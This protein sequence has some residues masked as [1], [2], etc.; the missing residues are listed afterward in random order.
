MLK[1]FF[2]LAF[3]NLSKNKS[4]AFVNI[5]GL[6]VGVA[7]C[8]LSFLNY[9][10]SR[11]F[12]K[13]HTN[14]ERIYR[15]DSKLLI[16]NEIQDWGTVPFALV[17][18]A[19]ENIPG[20]ELA[21]RF[22][23]ASGL[24][25]NGDRVFNERIR[26]VGKD[27]FQIFTF[28]VE[29]G[30]NN[31]FDQKGRVILSDRYA[32]KYFGDE[33]PIGRTLTIKYDNGTERDYFVE[34]VL[35]KYPTNSSLYIDMLMSLE[36]HNEL[37]SYDDSSWDQWSNASFLLLN[38]SADPIE[39][40]KML[41]DKVY[42]QNQSNSERK[43]DRYYLDKLEDIALHSEA[44]RGE[45][46][47]SGI[48]ESSV[49][50]PIVGSFLIFF[51]ACFNFINTAIATSSSRL[52]EI[53][54]RKV[55]GGTRKQLIAQFLGENIILSILGL[56]AGLMI[57]IYYV[58]FYSSLWPFLNI[59]LNFLDPGLIM[60]LGF[61]LVLIGIAA[62]SYPA[63]H[64][65]K[66]NPVSIL[67]GRQKLGGMTISKR[68]LLVF[69][70]SFSVVA[71]VMIF[72]LQRNADFQRNFDLGFD[73]SRMVIVPVQNGANY[74]LL[75]AA[76]TDDSEIEQ[77]AAS[78]HIPGYSATRYD[79][80]TEKGKFVTRGLRLGEKYFDMIKF[81][82]I[83]GRRFDDSLESEHDRSIMV[84]QL[85]VEEQEWEQPIDRVIKVEG[86]QYTVIGVVEDFYQSGVWTEK[87]PLV[88]TYSPD[89]EYRYATIKIN[90]NNLQAMRSKI[91]VEFRKLFPNLPYDAFY[92]DDLILNSLIVNDNILLVSVIQSIAS[93]IISC[94]GLY[95]M[96][97]LSIARK[98]KE[99][100]I[101]KVLGATSRMM[102]N[103][104]SRDFAIL[105]LFSLVSGSIGGYILIDA[106]IGAIYAQT[107]GYSS[108]P[109]I[110]TSLILFISA[111][112]TMITLVYKASMSNP[113]ESLRY[114]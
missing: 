68:L 111:A 108:M 52:N 21:V 67:K 99:I 5:L 69:Q 2:K 70:F 9:D 77:I 109:F 27:F 110:Y 33:D 86:K 59:E 13:F 106:L 97:A 73:T 7:S 51:L 63:F 28:P 94:M 12:D 54:I 23:H 71:V 81:N 76:L 58:P 3:R 114:E 66:F 107:V 35:K 8:I 61:L 83:S 16:N 75:N 89:D 29:K 87:I 42:I 36:E 11:S 79:I 84:N 65:S 17:P 24:T 57:S 31:I 112:V 92:G 18:D 45:I 34:G 62:G 43:V 50:G 95:A 88:L 20:I 44:L 93:M 30:T 74:E 4:Y 98:V 22:D 41:Q 37:F 105:L 25:K 48:P 104:V 102:A 6:G 39:I 82:L 53:G 19:A 38:E 1:S 60:F 78:N 10:Y 113:A 14:G 64:V 101:R 26:F 15:V 49:M 47:N 56:G 100:G 55:V 96:V 80:E 91:E 72:Q 85:F 32:V 90:H 103:L 46:L 40:E